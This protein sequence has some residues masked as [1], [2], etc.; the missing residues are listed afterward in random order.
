[1]SYEKAIDEIN[2]GAKQ[3]YDAV[4][5]KEKQ[6]GGIY[7]LCFEKAHTLWSMMHPDEFQRAQK[8]TMSEMSKGKS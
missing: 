8:Q 4:P 6:F 2:A 1:M 7:H 5:E 3:F